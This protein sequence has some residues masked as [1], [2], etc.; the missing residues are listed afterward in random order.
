M[1]ITVASFIATRASKREAA[2]SLAYSSF[3]AS[4]RCGD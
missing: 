4:F 1:A 3:S 2:A